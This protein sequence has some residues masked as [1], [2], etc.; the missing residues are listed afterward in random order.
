MKTITKGNIIVEDIEIGDI[1][2]E[3]DFGLGIKC[4]VITKPTKDQNGN[5]VWKSKNLK[6]N[7]IIEYLVNPEIIE[8]RFNKK[9]DTLEMCMNKFFDIVFICNLK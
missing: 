8:L 3:Y 7:K 9:T 4:E 6:S 2:Y 5:W 1:H